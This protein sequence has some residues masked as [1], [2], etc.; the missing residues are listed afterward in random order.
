MCTTEGIYCADVVLIPLE[1]GDRAEALVKVGKKVI[2]I[3]LNPLSRTAMAAH[4]TIVDELT[5]AVPTCRH[6]A[7]G[8]EADPEERRGH[9]SP[10]STTREPGGRHGGASARNCEA[11][12]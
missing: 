12:E 1:D 4:V 11:K 9:L 6:G 8:A 7:N 10:R 2:A 5:R 3:D